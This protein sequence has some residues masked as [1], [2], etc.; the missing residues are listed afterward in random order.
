MA[1]TI[2]FGGTFD[3]VHRGHLATAQAAVTA[4][5]AERCRFIPARV[6]PHKQHVASAAP[7]HRLAMLRLATA[8]NPQ[9][10]V[11][12][13]E[14]TRPVPP[15]SYTIDTLETLHLAY[16]NDQL[17]WLLGADQLAKFATWH[18]IGDILALVELA[19]LAR[20]GIS[21]EQGLAQIATKLGDPVA[22][23][24]AKSIVP[25]PLVDISA[26]EIRR[27]SAAGA[28]QQSLELLV[29]PAVAAYILAHGLY[30]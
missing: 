4:L 3:P 26:T 7:E 8:N 27:Q 25:A 19:I 2:L 29:P 21:L 12:D 30:R 11:D 16:P 6:S 18:R 10:L 14:L 28:S 23:R 17:I 5:A 22:H 24:L 13:L 15:P 9:L 1:K 20:P